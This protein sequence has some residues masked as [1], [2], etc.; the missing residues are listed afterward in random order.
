MNNQKLL[1]ANDYSGV[2]Y[3]FDM[4]KLKLKKCIE[5]LDENISN[6]IF[7]IDENK[8]LINKIILNPCDC[9]ECGLRRDY[10]EENG[11][12][13]NSSFVQ[14]FFGREI[15]KFPEFEK[16]PDVFDEI[17]EIDC[18]DIIVFNK[19]NLIIAYTQYN[20]YFYEFFSL[21][22]IKSYRI[23][24]KEVIK[25]D[26]DYL[27]IIKTNYSLDDQINIIEFWKII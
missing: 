16:I 21:Q 9:V 26:D 20:L 10:C 6:T 1:V 14:D 24:L 27:A 19:K 4:K 18:N 22:N 12:E 25:I 3:L 5:E 17:N 13:L 2:I 8:I 11:L 7:K 15:V 23:D